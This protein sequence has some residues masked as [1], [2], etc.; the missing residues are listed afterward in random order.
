VNVAFVRSYWR[1]AHAA[2]PQNHKI[3]SIVQRWWAQARTSFFWMFGIAFVLR[4]TL[5]ILG[6]TYK[7]KPYDNGFSFGRVRESI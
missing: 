7:F 5:I 1:M 6:H 3:G 4:L 2:S